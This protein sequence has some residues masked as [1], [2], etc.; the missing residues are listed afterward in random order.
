M[1]DGD[2]RVSNEHHVLERL[3]ELVREGLSDSTEFAQ[4]DH[5]VHERLLQTY[6]E[7]ADA[8]A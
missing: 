4:L 6:A 8:I 1:G 3:F 2:K 7:R 5:L